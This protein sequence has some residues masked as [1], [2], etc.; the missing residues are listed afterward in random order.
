MDGLCEDPVP[1]SKRKFDDLQ[2]MKHVLPQYCHDYFDRLPHQ[3]VYIGKSDN[4]QN[5]SSYF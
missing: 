2:S 5:N 1:I 3:H 4:G